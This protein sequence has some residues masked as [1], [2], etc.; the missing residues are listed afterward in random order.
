MKL[1]EFAALLLVVA[2]ASAAACGSSDNHS[3]ARDAGGAGGEGGGNQP[4]D[5][6]STSSSQAGGSHSGDQAGAGSAGVAGEGTSGEAGSPAGGGGPNS[7]GG[8]AAGQSGEAGQGG[9]G[10]TPLACETRNFPGTSC[11]GDT[12][13][14]TG[15]GG[16]VA[17]AYACLPDIQ[18]SVYRPGSGWLEL[19]PPTTE[20]SLFAGQTFDVAVD[21]DGRVY[22]AMARIGAAGS[23]LE[24]LR[25]TGI[26]W[27]ALGTSIAGPFS[28]VRLKAAG[29]KVYVAGARNDGQ[30]FR[31]YGFDASDTDWQPYPAPPA[32]LVAGGQSAI[33]L[34]IDTEGE[35]V[36]ATSVYAGGDDFDLWLARFVVNGSGPSGAW[37]A[38][39]V[40]DTAEAHNPSLVVD[41]ETMFVLY[42][43]GKHPQ[44]GVSLTTSELAAVDWSS[45]TVGLGSIASEASSTGYSTAL[46]GA[47]DKLLLVTGGSASRVSFY[48]RVADELAPA[49]P[50]TLSTLSR[51]GA[52]ALNGDLFVSGGFNLAGVRLE[53]FPGD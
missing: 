15:G 46:A 18:V 52:I 17:I 47:G 12:A 24:V 11:Q 39:L 37:E 51:Y 45:T 25:F 43:L 33:A 16:V 23:P 7:D 28:S 26:A 40:D 22:F 34:A 49:A 38:R 4:R 3:L 44:P 9:D 8:G 48:D 31:A 5:G 30:G 14:A 27:E 32:A 19:P 41:G 36:V 53:C 13:L 42:H 21:N 1:V 10:A 2:S 35:P 6:G 50:S 20:L 29:T